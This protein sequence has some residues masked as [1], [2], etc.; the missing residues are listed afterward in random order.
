MTVSAFR[1][2]S[3]GH[4]PAGKV[5]G[6]VA[7]VQQPVVGSDGSTGA[8]DSGFELAR[9]A[10]PGADCSRDLNTSVVARGEV[11]AENSEFA[12][13][14]DAVT[15]DI[16]DFGRVMGGADPIGDS[17]GPLV[18]GAS[19]AVVSEV[20]TRENVHPEIARLQE[21]DLLMDM[22]LAMAGYDPLSR[23]DLI[24]E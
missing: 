4:V 20:A 21:L 8:G 19:T 17:G 12:R 1:Q 3:G 9:Q 10:A 18:N 22:D 11:G 13:S 7:I 23:E 14:C 6:Q 24:R 2:I 16:I 5:D 15:R